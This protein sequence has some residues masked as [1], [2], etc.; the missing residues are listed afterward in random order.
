MYR[1]H[2]FVFQRPLNSRVRDTFFLGKFAKPCFT[3][4]VFQHIA[5]ELLSG[6]LSNWFMHLELL[7]SMPPR[8]ELG[9]MHCGHL[10]QIEYLSTNKI[11][12]YLKNIPRCILSL[13]NSSKTQ[14]SRAEPELHQ[15]SLLAL[16]RASSA[17][18]KP[19]GLGEK[20]HLKYT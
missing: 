17:E 15:A 3:V 16:Q 14:P 7:I 8:Q 9:T 20:N 6:Y 13:A 2:P 18:K 4:A 1:G 10:L 5:V 11:H 12:E 19:L